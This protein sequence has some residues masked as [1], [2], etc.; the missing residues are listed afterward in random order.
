MSRN[1]S[2]IAA[3]ATLAC[4]LGLAACGQADPSDSV[5]G[6]WSASDRPWRIELRADRTVAMSTI[7]PQRSGTYQ[8]DAAKVLRIHL[9][10][11]QRFIATIRMAGRDQMFLTS[12]GAAPMK[13]NRI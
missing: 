5:V 2:T 12:P 4:G 11:G 1:L 7:G 8:L 13:F 3:S 9:H 10:D 6:N